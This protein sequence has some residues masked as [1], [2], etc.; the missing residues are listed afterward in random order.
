MRASAIMAIA[1]ALVLSP[2][3]FAQTGKTGTWMRG[4]NANRETAT[5]WQRGE[6]VRFEWSAPARKRGDLLVDDGKLVSLF[7]RAENSVIQTNSRRRPLNLELQNERSVTV[8][9]SKFEFSPPRGAKVLRI[10][11]TLYGTLAAA[12][13]V[14]NWFKIP[15]N[16]PA[17]FEFENAIVGENRVWLRYSDG[18]TMFSLFQQKAEAG[19]IAP[20]KVRGGWFWR[21]DGIRFL[22]TG[23]SDELARQIAG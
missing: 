12:R 11:G 6:K 8:P 21:R 23:A 2:A 3:A 5:V 17:N 10:D 9:D 4:E 19:E 22:L 7:H 16:V 13:R 18:K 1:G 15:Q 20:Q 14:A